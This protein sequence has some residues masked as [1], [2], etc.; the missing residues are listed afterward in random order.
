MKNSDTHEVDLEKMKMFFEIKGTSFTSIRTIIPLKYKIS[1]ISKFVKDRQT[2][3]EDG[4]MWSSFNSLFDF[5]SCEVFY[6][7][8]K[9]S[10]TQLWIAVSKKTGAQYRMIK[11]DN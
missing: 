5:K 6:K 9:Q 4:W 3:L 10:N 2:R 8:Y 11:S 1:A 7:R